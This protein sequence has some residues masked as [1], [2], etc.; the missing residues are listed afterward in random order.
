MSII[1]RIKNFFSIEEEEKEQKK[2]YSVK[3][4]CE[5][6]LHKTHYKIEIK[7]NAIEEIKKIFCIN[8]QMKSLSQINEDFFDDMFI[9]MK[10]E[11]V[12]E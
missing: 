6:C 11:R 10:N 12:E 4:L 7:K 5:N 2:D 3:T 8:C 9:E 1:N